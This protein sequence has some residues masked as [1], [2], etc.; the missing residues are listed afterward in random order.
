MQIAALG[1]VGI[2]ATNP[3][4]WADF[5]PSVLGMVPSQ[6]S[7]DGAVLLRMDERSYRLGIHPGDTNRL[8]YMGWE[9]PSP[10]ALDDVYQQLENAGVEPR[11]A[12]PEQCEARQ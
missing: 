6:E 12:A 2:E 10:A 11:R 5:G 3:Q 4:A 7:P 9:V 8:A 1:Y